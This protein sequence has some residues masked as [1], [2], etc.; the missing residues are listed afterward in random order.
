MDDFELELKVGFLDEASQHLGDA[1]QCFLSLEHNPTEPQI[2]E[3]IF[4]LAHN[5]KGSAKAV[6]FDEMGA[7]T[8]QLESLLLKI[9]DGK[10][11]PNAKMVT[12]L[13]RCNDHLILMIDALKADL[14]AHVDSSEL[15][16]QLVSAIEGRMGD[17]DEVAAS[18]TENSES[19]ASLTVETD[20]QMSGSVADE[21][22]VPNVPSM[23]ETMALAEA[24]FN[25]ATQSAKV[26][27]LPTPTPA[28][29]VI[30]ASPVE[31]PGVVATVTPISTPAGLMGGG[32]SA[33]GAKAPGAPA[34]KPPVSDES[35]RISL[36]RLEQ[37]LNFVGEM[38]ILQTVLK[39]QAAQVDHLLLRKTVHQLGKVTKEVQDISMGLRMVA[40]KPTFQK[41]QRIVRDTAN[42]LGKRI[43]L[44]LSGDETEIDKTVLDNI[45][46][47]LV[48]IIRNAVDHGIEAMDERIRSGKPETGNIFLRAMQRSGRL[49]L[50]IED[51]G[52]GINAEVLKRKAQEK[53]IIRPGQTMSDK[54]AIHLIFHPGFSTKAQVTEVSGRGVGMDVV[55]TN[56]EALQG[57]IDIETQLGAG[58]RFSISLPLTLAIIDGM[59][60]RAADERYVIPLSQVHESYRP[61]K[62][63]L[64]HKT[65]IG[66]VLLM[67]GESLPTFRLAA[68]LNR[69]PSKSDGND[70]GIAIVV[71]NGKQ[72]FSLLV[73]DI[74]GQQQVVIKKLGIEVQ[75]I[76]GISGS[77]I[78]GDGRPALILE[79]AELIHKTATKGAA[80]GRA[81]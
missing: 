16:E 5:L 23:D 38:V 34:T 45:A 73:D 69:R 15:T 42:V 81:V 53:G 67:R 24:M 40:L 49:V 4:R 7:F 1:E 65:G 78:L 56:I 8:H 74:I 14:S 52:G 41:M 50:E 54:E 2:I 58:S 62:E 18:D 44:H 66:E 32:A 59:V 80:I 25:S 77:A 19:L 3:K 47:P 60:V 61:G 26:I 27:D 30:Q 71:K 70:C 64:Q 46:D 37:L 68:L 39:E 29:D 63:E 48:H 22:P 33:P 76:K 36:G 12:L 79:P 17:A 57:E 20:D 75:N 6:G 51:D 35:I 55:R 11:I 31:P 43:N 9:K 28:P 21:V 72:N 10:I 13:L